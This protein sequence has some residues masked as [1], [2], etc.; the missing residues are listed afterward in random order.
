MAVRVRVDIAFGARRVT[1]SAVANSGYESGRPEVV[2]PASLARRKF[3]V[4]KGRKRTFITPAGEVQFVELGE[5]KVRAIAE[6]RESQESLCTI[7]VSPHE[8]EI[9]LNDKLI[10][11]LGLVLVHA[12]KGIWR[13]QE[14]SPD[15][16][17]QSVEKQL[18]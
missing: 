1:T 3:G 17:R 2:V 13:F 7:I 5:G 14:D 12:G 6:D 16:E 18:W 15:R 8:Q 9:L 11:E 10:D 4:V